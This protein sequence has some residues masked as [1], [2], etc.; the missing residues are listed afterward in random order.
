MLVDSRLVLPLAMCLCVSAAAGAAEKPRVVVLAIGASSETL[1]PIAAS[2]AEQL[3]TELGRTGRLE[4][5]G[6]SDVSA[7]LGLERQKTMLGCTDQSS[8]C[9][10]EISAALGAPWLVTGNL[11]QLGKAMRVDVKLIRAKDGKAVF[12]DGR[13]V[14][15]ESEIFDIVSEM[16]KRMVESMGLPAPE[17]AAPVAKA[18]DAPKATFVT[19]S[20]APTSSPAPGVTQAAVAP[21]PRV[22]PWVVTGLGAAAL[23]LG[24]I[25]LS[26]GLG[27]RSSTLDAVRANAGS[28]STSATP[29]YSD[30]KARLDGANGQITV[31]AVG[32]GVGALALAGGLA[33]ALLGAPA[34]P[35]AASVTVSPGPGS[36]LVEG[37]F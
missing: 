26:S 28:P 6:T 7:V 36:V 35:A 2:V 34:E 23:A 5:M 37:R 19:P 31:G 29:S 13:N 9:L 11:A 20:P 10:A 22:A 15:D 17:P 30:A 18:P 1:K 33:W 24:G 8:S 25:A 32:L 27:A 4:V 3:L 21:G 16:A 14:K 12:R